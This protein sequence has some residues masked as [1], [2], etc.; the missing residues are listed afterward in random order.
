M[1]HYS[2]TTTAYT[3]APSTITAMQRWQLFGHS[4]DSYNFI[5][6]TMWL[7]R[8]RDAVHHLSHRYGVV[9]SGTFW[10]FWY[11]KIPF[12]DVHWQ[13]TCTSMTLKTA[14]LQ[15][16]SF[17][18]TKS[19]H[20]LPPCGMCVAHP[21]PSLNHSPRSPT[22][23]YTYCHNTAW[24][25]YVQH[26]AILSWHITGDIHT[27]CHKLNIKSSASRCYISPTFQLTQPMQCP[28][29]INIW[30]IVVLYEWFYL[31]TYL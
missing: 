1:F 6:V 13:L 26:H 23:C 28:W 9:I 7:D 2:L 16:S 14:K 8:F 21:S 31:F 18:I 5:Q 30:I 25:I 10:Y 20:L 17:D 12:K 27:Q 4:R 15:K 11:K 22:V 19:N 24:V 3:K 29:F